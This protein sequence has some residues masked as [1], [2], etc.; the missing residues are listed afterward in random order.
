MDKRL[1]RSRKDRMIS[2]VCGGIAHYF[3]VDPTLIRLAFILFLFA[4]GSG[5]LAYI[6]G[7]IIIPEGD[8]DKEDDVEVY[9][10]DGSQADVDPDYRQK[11]T[12]Q[13]VGYGLMVVGAALLLNNFV[14]WFDSKLLW[15]AGIVA[16][17]FYLIFDKK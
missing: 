11:K 4:G 15:G 7:A 2:G 5:I 16:I 6:I 12:K 3:E 13:F 1:Y 9:N 8:Y 14:W 10:E 17:G